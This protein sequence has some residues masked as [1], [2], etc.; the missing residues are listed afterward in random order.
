VYTIH[1]VDGWKYV[2]W[3]RLEVKHTSPP[4]TIWAADVLAMELDTASPSS[5]VDDGLKVY[6]EETGQYL[7]VQSGESYTFEDFLDDVRSCG[8]ECEGVPYA[9]R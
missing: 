1:D 8:V 5:T 3:Q 7:F 2:G 4:G 6:A 9:P